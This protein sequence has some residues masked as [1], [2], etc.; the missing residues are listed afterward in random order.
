MHLPFT[1]ITEIM[2]WLHLTF[3]TAQSVTHGLHSQDAPGYAGTME[4]IIGVLLV[5]CHTDWPG[6][7][8][9]F[10]CEDWIPMPI[11]YER[12]QQRSRITRGLMYQLLLCFNKLTTHPQRMLFS[13]VERKSSSLHPAYISDLLHRHHDWRDQSKYYVELKRKCT[14][15][16]DNFSDVTHIFRTYAIVPFHTLWTTLVFTILCSSQT[17]F[18]SVCVIC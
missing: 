11:S 14:K 12:F 6:A 4:T 16:G 18:S 15:E 5:T 13:D 1:Q 17:A 10:P 3:A 2:M 9:E 7:W 8:L